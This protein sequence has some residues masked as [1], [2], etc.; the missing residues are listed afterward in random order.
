MCWACD[1]IRP[2]CNFEG[3]TSCSNC[4]KKCDGSDLYGWNRAYLGVR[5]SWTKETLEELDMDRLELRLK[6]YNIFVMKQR[7]HELMVCKRCGM[8]WMGL[9]KLEHQW[10]CRDVGHST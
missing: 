2:G 9:K 10:K 8:K 4:G 6:N 1:T 7:K 3:Y 5:G